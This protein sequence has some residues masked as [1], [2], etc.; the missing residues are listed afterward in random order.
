V[1]TYWN[2]EPCKADKVKVIVGECK[3]PTWWCADLAGKTHDAIRITYHGE[4]FYLNDDES[5]WEKITVGRG[6]P[7]WPHK[8]LPVEKEITV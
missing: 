3:V 6:S 5:S 8:S 4:T 1:K 2:G 7:Y